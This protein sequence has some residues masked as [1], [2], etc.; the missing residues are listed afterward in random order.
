MGYDRKADETVIEG[1]GNRTHL[2]GSEGGMTERQV[3]CQHVCWRAGQPQLRWRHEKLFDN[4]VGYRRDPQQTGYFFRS[5][6]YQAPQQLSVRPI[7]RYR[8]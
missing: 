2:A 4:E 8:P 6:Q 7:S 1:L 3:F 5:G